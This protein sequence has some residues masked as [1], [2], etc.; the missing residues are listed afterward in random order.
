MKKQTLF[1]FALAA[2]TAVTMACSKTPASP[3]SPAGGSLTGAEAGID[4]ATLKVDAPALVSPV[5]GIEVTDRSPVLTIKNVTGRF[6]SVPL[7]YV[8]QV[9]DEDGAVVYTSPAVP[10]G[11]GGQTSHEVDRNLDFNETHTWRAWAVYQNQRGPRPAVA[12]FKVFSLFGISCARPGIQ[13]VEIVACRFEQHGG[14][15][16]MD[17]E[18]T[19]QFMKEV[20]FDLNQSVFSDKGGFGVLIKTSGNNCLGYSCDI[21]CEGN[22]PDQNQFDILIDESIPNWG[23]VGEGLVVRE[24]EIIK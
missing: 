6:A 20:A 3:T 18:E 24:C 10:A 21:I 12:S 16:G 5:G 8:F 14:A 17:H 19:I 15:G 2:T 22:G 13:P 4:G 11:A 7:S 9:V 1:A 23:E